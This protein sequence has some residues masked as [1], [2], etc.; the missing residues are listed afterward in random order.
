[1]AR[2]DET[3][4]AYAKL[5]YSKDNPPKLWDQGCRRCSVCKRNW[6]NVP[7]FSPSPCCN[8]QAGIVAD[9]MPDMDWPSAYHDLQ[10][11][12]FER[13]YEK[14]NEGTSDVELCWNTNDEPSEQEI[15]EGLEKLNSFISSMEE[16]EAHGKIR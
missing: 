7:E 13:F 11:F 5:D 10:M 2:S 6:P 8:H 3:F 12:R 4:P 14:Y 9:G 1:M 16:E 15:S